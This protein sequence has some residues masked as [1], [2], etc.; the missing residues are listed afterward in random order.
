MDEIA[1][2]VKNLSK[3]YHLYESPQHRLR[4]ALHPFRKKYH[5]DFWAL[6]DVSFEMKKGECIGIIGKNGS[7]KSTLLQL[8]CGVLQPTGGEVALNGKVTALLELGT[9]FN[10]EFTGR[11][12]VYMNGALMGFARDEMDK[13]FQA[14]ADF[15]DI[16][17]FT[18]QP[19][20]TYSSGMYVRLAFAAAVNVDAD[21]LIVDEALAVGDLSFAQKCMDYMLT[22]FEEKTV[23]LVSHNIADIK[24]LCK[25][26]IVLDRGVIHYLGHPEQAILEY[27]A[28][29]ERDEKARQATTV[30]AVDTPRVDYLDKKTSED[31]FIRLK[32]IN[33]L[34]TD[35]RKDWVETNQIEFGKQFKIEIE[36][37]IYTNLNRPEFRISFN[38]IE[39]NMLVCSSSSRTALKDIDSLKGLC[40]A[41]FI[42]PRPLLFPREYFLNIAICDQK[43]GLYYYSQIDVY[44]LFILFPETALFEDMEVG[45]GITHMEREFSLVHTHGHN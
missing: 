17:E 4:E 16:G 7:G 18:D 44:R 22:L 30:P 14:I 36:Y 28:I 39:N 3:K 15:A 37:E 25:R 20:K 34:T 23:I 31:T 2:S 11:Q 41:S 12:N 13:R 29:L 26:I 27:Y 43:S 10:P 40:K 19:V 9:G 24:R 42:F 6:R 35:G 32:S 8:L 5:R 33:S 1:I 45:K 38:T 21:V